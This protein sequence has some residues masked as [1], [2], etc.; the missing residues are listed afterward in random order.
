MKQ[1]FLLL[2]ITTISL[3]TN[4]QPVS[5]R[6]FGGSGS[7]L[8]SCVKPTPDGGFIICG[9]SNSFGAGGYDVYVIKTN[10]EGEKLWSK[11][12]GGAGNDYGNSIIVTTDG[13]YVITGSSKSFNWSDQNMYL[14]KI[15]ATGEITWSKTFGGYGSDAGNQVIE[16][17]D[18]GYAVTGFSVYMDGLKTVSLVKTDSLGTGIFEAHYAFNGEGNS[19]IENPSGYIINGTLC[20]SDSLDKN[21]LIRTDL[22]GN[23]IWSKMFDAP[24]SLN[25][26]DVFMESDGGYIATGS[27]TD[28][29]SDVTSAYIIKTD[30]LGNNLSMRLI[31]TGC[32]ASFTK[33][34]D[35]YLISGNLI[36]S[37]GKKK[38]YLSK[39][40][41]IGQVQ[42]T[43]VFGGENN[44]MASC[45]QPLSNGGFVIAGNTWSTSEEFSDIYLVKTTV[46]GNTDCSQ[47]IA[48]ASDSI[49][50][51]NSSDYVFP[52][53]SMYSTPGAY[54]LV[55]YATET[56]SLMNEASETML[57]LC[58]G[59]DMTLVQSSMEIFAF[60]ESDADVIK[61]TETNE[62]QNNP[63]SDFS[64]NVFP[65]PGNGSEINFSVSAEEGDHVVVVVYDV[66]GK[67][68]FSKILVVEAEGENI[69]GIDPENKLAKGVYFITASSQKGN[70]SRKLIV[71]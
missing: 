8:T 38:V 39:T 21:L 24:L 50:V 30:S 11:T 25:G 42:W 13:S 68:H 54:W 48:A 65:N 33:Y 41:S 67:Q 16:T 35:G 66:T 46:N 1:F 9:S 43:N 71:E 58:L 18:G 17:S 28:I 60:E 31:A 4:A 45:V 32:P 37:L 6:S 56:S 7:E 53:L 20:S 59:S 52:A 3:L 10:A 40:D 29:V 12:Y 51:A 63:V 62:T 55:P 19:I 2:V 70:F 34:A 15:N 23:K 22:Y 27:A 36:T 14:L 5:E 69:F 57:A 26:Q 47:T 61:T 64:F 49:M 44:Y